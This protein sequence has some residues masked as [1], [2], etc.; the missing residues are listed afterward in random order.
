MRT[1]QRRRGF[2]LIELLVVIAIIAILIALLLPAVQQ[3]RE[4]ARRTECKDNLHNINVALHN[5]HELFGSFPMGWAHRAGN[6]SNAS[7]R[8]GH[9]WHARILPQ[10][11][12]KN[13]YDQNR[14]QIGTRSN[15]VRMSRVVLKFLQCPSQPRTNN[16]RS[17]YS[18]NGGNLPVVCAT[19]GMMATPDYRSCLN[20][21][22]IFMVNRVM[23][24]R[25][26]R[27]GNVNTIIVA[28]VGNDGSYGVHYYNFS[29]AFR[30]SLNVT[31]A[32]VV[33]GYVPTTSSST[34][35]ILTS[36]NQHSSGAG[37]Y[38]T[39]GCHVALCDGS[40][41]FVSEN[42]AVAVWQNALA[43]NDGSTNNLQ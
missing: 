32:L 20:G 29:P 3:A 19:G 18:G 24:F 28:E 8:S 6:T 7:L 2:T 33:S 31:E 40:A 14:R 25:D 16:P 26:V 42:I 1:T 38:H 30:S 35:R 13:L 9:T 34:A 36:I 12:Q 10:L 15:S 23:R 37:S 27:D 5:Y 43:R 11:E 22:G 17:S 4:A 39:G 41:R 21:N